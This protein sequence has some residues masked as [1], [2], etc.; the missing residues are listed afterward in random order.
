MSSRGK[1]TGFTVQ[2]CLSLSLF[3]RK[4]GNLIKKMSGEDEVPINKI[5]REERDSSD[6][7]IQSVTSGTGVAES[8]ASRILICARMRSVDSVPAVRSFIF[9]HR[10]DIIRLFIPI[11]VAVESEGRSLI[12]PERPTSP[13]RRLRIV[14]P[15]RSRPGNEKEM[16]RKGR[17]RKVAKG[18]LNEDFTSS[19]HRPFPNR[20]LSWSWLIPSK[21]Q[22]RNAGARHST[23]AEV[24]L[25]ISYFRE[26]ENF[27]EATSLIEYETNRR[28]TLRGRSSCDG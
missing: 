7:C 23:R 6:V 22:T 10:H 9:N 25:Y 14:I 4:G 3:G 12:C 15:D 11:R 26:C 19:K 5:A 21:R 1:T 2:L 24:I 28:E 13:H 17:M 20:E 27:R 18:K 8:D 16:E